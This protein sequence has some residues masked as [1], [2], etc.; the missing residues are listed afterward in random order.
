MEPWVL[1]LGDGRFHIIYNGYKNHQPMVPGCY[2]KPCKV[3]GICTIATEQFFFQQVFWEFLVSQKHLIR[4]KCRQN[5][6][7]Y[8]SSE[9]LWSGVVGNLMGGTQVIPQIRCLQKSFPVKCSTHWYVWSSLLLVLT[10]NMRMTCWHRWNP[11]QLFSYQRGVP[12]L[13]ERWQCGTD[14]RCPSRWIVSR[15]LANLRKQQLWVTVN[16]LHEQMEQQQQQR[17]Q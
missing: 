11:F 6:L 12:S 1:A 10:I 2:G 17:Q 3:R 7:G 15:I 14:W 13:R 4:L 16:F 9:A 8:W 5:D